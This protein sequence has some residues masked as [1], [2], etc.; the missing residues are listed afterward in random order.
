[1]SAASDYLEDKVYRN[2]LLG[3]AYTPPT[4]IFIGLHT[5][6]PGDTGANEVTTAAFP[7]YARQD[8]AKGG[9][10]DQGWQVPVGGSGKNLLQLVFPVFNGAAPLT[11]THYSLWDAAT[12]GNCLVL[13]QLS[14]ARTLNP[15]DIF[16]I[17]VQKLTITVL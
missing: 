16:V 10:V 17:D 9:T 15:N 11:I 5:A 8:A 7:A 6:S 4:K 3:Q 1:M 2:L 14:T 13:G 12:A